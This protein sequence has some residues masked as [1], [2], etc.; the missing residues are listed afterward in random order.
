VNDL[1]AGRIA[2]EIARAGG[3]LGQPLTVVSVTG[4]TNDDARE[5]ASRG[6]PHGA[7]FIA[8]AQTGGR[9]RGGHVWHS[10][11]GEN[12]YMSV[13]LRPRMEATALVSIPLTIGAAVAEIIEELAGSNPDVPRIA[14]KWPNDVL[15][16]RRKVAG[17]LVEG[18]FRGTEMT[19]LVVGIGINVRTAN[20]PDA[21]AAHATSLH[22]LGGVDLDRSALA[23]ALLCRIER[24]VRDFERA[25]LTPFL[26]AIRH[27]D[28]LLGADVEAGGTRG[29]AA[30]IDSEGRLLIRDAAGREHRVESGT[31]AW[32]DGGSAAAIS[33]S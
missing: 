5:A 22:L 32:I 17:I 7:V 4:S 12:L 2:Q 18:Q 25:G 8:D 23:A 19:S 14:L 3:T 28:A 26:D 21:I 27:R 30:G 33:S 24:A 10:P 13:L 29:T 16:A 11:P 9:G 31:V 15:A 20:F 6:A 1:D